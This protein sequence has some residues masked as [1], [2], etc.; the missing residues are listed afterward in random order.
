MID[1]GLLV[2]IMVAFGV[3]SLVALWWPI[4]VGPETRQGEPRIG[5]V[6][7]A[8]GA[9]IAGVVVGR[10][11]TLLLDDPTSIGSISDM[12]IIRS[13]VEF[14]PGVTAAVAFVWWSERR[15]GPF[16]HTRLV[17]L[18]PLAMVGYAAYEA[19]CIFRDGCFG[20]ESQIGLRPPGVMTPMFPV[21]WAMAIALLAAAWATRLLAR[22]EKS[23]VL[24]VSAATAAVAGVRSVGS[25]WLPHV[26]DGLTR[27]HVTSIVIG[28][29]AA[30]VVAG[31]GLA[32]QSSQTNA[33]MQ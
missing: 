25:I 24:I 20:P 15:A 12:L 32:S 19:A 9:A 30:L 2:S 13:G 18:V 5:F 10:L 14:W 22:R 21:G 8:L 31:V 28:S 33:S 3:P 6:D 11:A 4:E 17:G 7:A 26:G 16:S 29:G 23:P 27:Q 1:Y